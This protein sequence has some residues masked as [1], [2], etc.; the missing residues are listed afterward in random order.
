MT[1][2]VFLSSIRL[3]NQGLEYLKR[4]R[5]EDAIFVFTQALSI[6]LAEGALGVVQEGIDDVWES[7]DQDYCF[8]ELNLQCLDSEAAVP[9]YVFTKPIMI[10]E[11][12]IKNADRSMLSAVKISVILTYNLALTNHFKAIESNSMDAFERALTLYELVHNFQIQED[13]E[14]C[15]L[16]SLALVNNLGHV[17]LALNNAHRSKECFEYLLETLMFFVEGGECQKYDA[18]QAFFRSTIHLILKEKVVAAAA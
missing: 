12:P 13:M 3:N 5:Y 10:P 18:M 6:I 11:E 15:I 8:V 9:S 14:L 2:Q 7:S 16:H 17:H 1:D 4:R